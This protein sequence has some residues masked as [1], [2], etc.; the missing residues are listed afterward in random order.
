MVDRLVSGT[1]VRKNV[2]V[3]VS[4]RV[5][6]LT[7]FDGKHLIVYYKV[8]A[9]NFNS[10]VKTAYLYVFSAIGIILLVVVYLNFQ[11]LQ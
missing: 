1:S 3:Q 8:M 10:I 4:P 7:I 2:G 6:N 9:A 5:Q 11:I